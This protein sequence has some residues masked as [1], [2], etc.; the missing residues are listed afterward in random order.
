MEM[1]L[2]PYMEIKACPICQ[3]YPEH[4]EPTLIIR[5]KEYHRKCLNN[6][7]TL[8]D[9]HLEDKHKYNIVDDIVTNNIAIIKL[10]GLLED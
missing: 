2:K 5:R 8:L 6:I 9:K 7:W 1:N 10:V 4:Y 3:L